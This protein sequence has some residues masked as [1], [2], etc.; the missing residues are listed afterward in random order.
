MQAGGE[1]FGYS[2]AMRAMHW[3]TV[4]LL[5][6]AYS[7]AWMIDGA[8]S[9]AEKAW[10]IMLH[11]SFG[12]TV[13]LLTCVR[14]GFR[15]ITR[16]PRLRADVPET[17]RLAAR[18]SVVTLYTLLIVQ[19]LLGLTASML[20]GDRIVVFGSV[21]LPPLLPSDRALAHRI[22]LVHGW[23]ALAMLALIGVHV[24]AALHHHFIRKD[25]VLAA[26]LPGVRLL[27]VPADLE[28]VNSG[29]GLP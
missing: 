28:A 14:F 24:A 10:F 4:T 17:Q 27:A 1:L 23:V 22:F 20:H 3:A 18:A 12:V 25:A 7:A 29:R 9:P 8:S 5:L 16:V 11:H 6:G 15:R 13:L 26:M 21:V 19:P 2:R